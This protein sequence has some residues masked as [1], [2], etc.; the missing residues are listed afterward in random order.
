MNWK[1]IRDWCLKNDIWYLEID[2]DIPEVCLLEAKK[3]YEEG[4]FVKHRSGEG[5]DWYSCALH[6]WN[7]KEE[8]LLDGWKNTQSPR[9]KG[10]NFE[11]VDWGWTV[12]QE[13]APETKRWME[14]LPHYHYKLGR[15][16][17]L[18][19]NGYIG[20]HTDWDKRNVFSAMNV[21]LNHPKGCYLRRNDTKEEL[22][23][24]DFTGFWFDNGVEHE[25]G[26]NSNEDRFHFILH[27]KRG[28]D[29]REELIKKSLIK[30]FGKNILKSIDKNT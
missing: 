3:I 12:I 6:G 2:L 21:A 18:R 17:L 11:D 23:F 13:I 22:P 27:D 16:N 26:N 5:G 14:D 28:N 19:P 25:A 15:F 7:E 10:L 30:K 1:V 9:W 4:F 8:N 24:R 20:L 29:E